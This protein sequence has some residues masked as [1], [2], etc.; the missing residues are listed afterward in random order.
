MTTATIT[1]NHQT[2]H[3]ATTTVN[4]NRLTIMRSTSERQTLNSLVRASAL[5][6]TAYEDG[7]LFEDASKYKEEAYFIAYFADS[8]RNKPRALSDIDIVLRSYPSAKIAYSTTSVSTTTAARPSTSSGTSARPGSSAGAT[9]TSTNI[10]TPWY[11]ARILN[12]PAEFSEKVVANH[13]AIVE[14]SE[15]F[16][17]RMKYPTLVVNNATDSKEA[18]ALKEKYLKEGTPA[19]DTE[20]E[21]I[22]RG[23]YRLWLISLIYGA[24]IIPEPGDRNIDSDFGRF[25]TCYRCLGNLKYWDVKVV[26]ILM[27][28]FMKE[29]KPVF[30]YFK[31]IEK[32]VNEGFLKGDFPEAVAEEIYTGH[33]FNAFMTT[34]FP[35]NA[36]A[37]LNNSVKPLLLSER[38]STLSSVIKFT[39]PKDPNEEL[40]R[41]FL[42][43]DVRQ[44][45]IRELQ[46]PRSVVSGREF[47]ENVPLKPLCRILGD[48]LGHKL[49]DTATPAVKKSAWLAVELGRQESTETDFWGG[50]WGDERLR[51]WGYCLPKFEEEN[52]GAKKV[53]K[54]H[55][56]RLSSKLKLK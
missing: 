27:A 26:Q 10:P 43:K 12:G 9:S 39:T 29:L 5:F 14:L 47:E 8:L 16:I 11:H 54:G 21:T 48:G 38:F 4:C 40:L 23:L 52:T 32:V 50:V 24:N 3:D 49:A 22:I 1:M 19:T 2:S 35:H 31:R 55:L 36:T 33:Y 42:A 30:W 34:E 44:W 37:W 46:G 6:K 51:E 56:R 41:L 13:K 15:Q 25:V 17:S 20:K 28:F 45:H 53:W 7:M 18:A